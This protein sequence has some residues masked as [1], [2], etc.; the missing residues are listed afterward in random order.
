LIRFVCVEKTIDEIH[1]T[2]TMAG[3]LKTNK[4]INLPNTHV[5]APSITE[6]D[7][8]CVNWAIENDLDY[9]ALSFVRSPDDLNKLREHLTKAQS[10]MHLIAKIEKSEALREIEQLIEVSDG[11]RVARGD[12]GVEVD[13][14]TVPI[15]Q[16]DLIHRCQAAGKP[17]IVATQML[18]SMVDAASPTR[19]EVSDVAN[20]VYDGTDAVMLSGETS[21]GKFPILAVHTMTRVA[22]VT[23]AY[24]AK[25]DIDRGGPSRLKTLQTSAAV[26]R[27]VRQI[28][29]ELDMKLVVMWSQSGATARIFSKSR[30]PVPV[31][32]LSNDRRTLRQMAMYYGVL[33]QEMPAPE[34]IQELVANTDRLITAGQFAGPGDRIVIV[35]GA[36][37]ATPGTLNGVF[38]HTIGAQFSTSSI[39]VPPN[40]VTG[41]IGGAA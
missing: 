17:V 19:A 38:L 1:A 10:R 41:A 5:N 3:I 25:A 29:Q 22:E 8:D 20:A 23:E 18:Q 2:C 30:F 4:G 26:A 39:D 35:V 15:I 28:V 31:I 13:L 7:W 24:L 12:L 36:A 40:A 16:K 33:P 27:G 34:N 6:R 37:M 32:A 21:V 9:L 14:A 11:L